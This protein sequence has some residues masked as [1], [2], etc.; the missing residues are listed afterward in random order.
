ML[1]NFPLAARAWIFMV[2]SSAGV[3]FFPS[4]AT[5]ACLKGRPFEFGSAQAKHTE[6]APSSLSCFQS[7]FFT[8]IIN[9][10]TT[11]G[12]VTPCTQRRHY[13]AITSAGSTR[14]LYVAAEM[15]LLL[16]HKSDL[17]RRNSTPVHLFNCERQICHFS[18]SRKFCPSRVPFI[19]ECRGAFNKTAGIRHDRQSE[20]A[21]AFWNAELI[22]QIWPLRSGRLPV[23][24]IQSGISGSVS[25][26]SL[27]LSAFI[28][29][30]EGKSI[31]YPKLNLRKIKQRKRKSATL[32]SLPAA[33]LA[34]HTRVGNA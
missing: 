2:I 27:S 34:T 9:N 1:A 26:S 16:L 32:K 19:R 29:S 20:W 10:H 7:L 14:A 25:N 33:P 5:L 18:Y 12:T 15:E 3:F 8:S 24:W 21:S 28:G 6:A 22:P 17:V 13:A 31:I 30:K 11:F 4:A 23:D